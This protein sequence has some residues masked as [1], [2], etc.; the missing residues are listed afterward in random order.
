MIINSQTRKKIAPQKFVTHPFY[1]LT[2]LINISD[3]LLL[4]RHDKMPLTHVI[5]H[6]LLTST[7]DAILFFTFSQIA[8]RF[9]N[10]PILIV[11]TFSETFIFYNIICCNIAKMFVLSCKCFSF[12][13]WP[14]CAVRY[15]YMPSLY[16]VYKME[17]KNR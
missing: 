5:I 2:Q 4:N 6:V 16:S 9:L 17:T 12:W 13:S 10:R 3:W 14:V 8:S 7:K 11:D 1:Y 15:C